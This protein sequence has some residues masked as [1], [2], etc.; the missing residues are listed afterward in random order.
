MTIVS[1]FICLK[2]ALK[3]QYLDKL[4][5]NISNTYLKRSEEEKQNHPVEYIPNKSK[6]WHLTKMFRTYEDYENSGLCNYTI[7][8][9]YF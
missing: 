1:A 5:K 2:L 8:E 6:D 3:F 9:E 4:D 7:K